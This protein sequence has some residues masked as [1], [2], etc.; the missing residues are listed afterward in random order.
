MDFSSFQ[1]TPQM[2]QQKKDA[3]QKPVQLPKPPK[4]MIPACGARF[5]VKFSIFFLNFKNLTFFQFGGKLLTFEKISAEEP[6]TVSIFQVITD[7][8][9][10]AKA[11]RFHD[12][13][14]GGQLE[15]YCESQSM[16]SQNELE[17]NLWDLLHVKF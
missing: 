17:K 16:N 6:K 9:F 2:Q 11:A 12:I 4:W 15:I 1:L 13:L 8:E 5:G 10:Y 3:I 14:R 7:Q